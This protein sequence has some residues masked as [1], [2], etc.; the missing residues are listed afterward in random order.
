MRVPDSDLLRYD[1][2]IRNTIFA[3]GRAE[4]IADRYRDICCRPQDLYRKTNKRGTDE[5]QKAR[6][7]F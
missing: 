3:L 5:I 1:S 7:K 4:L 6:K 2:Y